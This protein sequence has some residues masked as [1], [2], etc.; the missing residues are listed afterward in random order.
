MSLSSPRK[1]YTDRVIGVGRRTYSW[2]T[3]PSDTHQVKHVHVTA[4]DN[5]CELPVSER[6][7]YAH[8]TDMWCDFRASHAQSSQERRS[9][10]A[11]NSKSTPRGKPRAIARPMTS[12]DSTTS[13]VICSDLSCQFLF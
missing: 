5:D 2:S 11:G 13:D 4:D 3:Q 10:L 1:G 8:P 9:S 6:K 12:V 7:R